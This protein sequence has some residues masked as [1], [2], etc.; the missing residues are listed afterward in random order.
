MNSNLKLQK[1]Q[2][3]N[4]EIYIYCDTSTNNLQ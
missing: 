2:I 1:L 3:P 4:D